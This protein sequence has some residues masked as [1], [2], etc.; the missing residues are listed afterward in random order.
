[1]KFRVIH[2]VAMASSCSLRCARLIGINDGVRVR[3]NIIIDP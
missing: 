2:S 1:M 3:V